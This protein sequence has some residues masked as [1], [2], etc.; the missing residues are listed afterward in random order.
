M[1]ASYEYT[2]SLLVVQDFVRT[3]ARCRAG[4]RSTWVNIRC[5][6]LPWPGRIPAQIG[7]CQAQYGLRS[8]GSGTAFAATSTVSPVFARIARIAMTW[9]RPASRRALKCVPAAAAER[10]SRP[11]TN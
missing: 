7:T 9:I 6:L 10:C 11:K 8:R 1:P 3:S 2:D 5:K 4:Q